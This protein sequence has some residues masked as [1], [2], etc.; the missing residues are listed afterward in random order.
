MYVSAVTD[1]EG[2][3]TV[4]RQVTGLIRLARTDVIHLHANNN[5]TIHIISDSTRQLDL[6][7]I[8]RTLPDPAQCQYELEISKNQ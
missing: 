1:R 4:E 8:Y 6:G 5:N 3:V 2:I 7:H